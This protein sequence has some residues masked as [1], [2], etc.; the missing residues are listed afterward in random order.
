[1][2]DLGQEDLVG[3]DTTPSRSLKQGWKQKYCKSNAT[4]TEY[5]EL[6]QR[7]IFIALQITDI[8]YL[9]IKLSPQGPY[10]TLVSV[11]L[12]KCMIFQSC[13]NQDTGL[14]K[15]SIPNLN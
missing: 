11:L 14:T 13:T 6:M 10:L 9:N 4:L 8:S 3:F 15:L 2:A 1:M 12:R 7:E 5:P